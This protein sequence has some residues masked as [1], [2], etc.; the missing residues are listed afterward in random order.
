LLR[1]SITSGLVVGSLLAVASSPAFCVS[2]VTRGG[3]SVRTIDFSVDQ[4]VT[5]RTLGADSGV[6]NG[7]IQQKV[8][9]KSWQPFL[10][11]SFVA[12]FDAFYVGV[13]GETGVTL[14]QADIKAS[15]RRSDEL[16]GIDVTPSYSDEAR[17][18][19]TDLGISLGWRG[20][21]N[22]VLFCGYKAGDT[23]FD[24]GR[25]ARNFS[26]HGPLVGVSYTFASDQGAL[27]VGSAYARLGGKYDEGKSKGVLARDIDGDAGGFS[28]FADW[29]APITQ[30]W[31][32][33][34]DLR[35]QKY[36]FDGDQ[37]SL[38]DNCGNGIVA[39]Q[40]VLLA[41]EFSVKETIYGVSVSIAY[42]FD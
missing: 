9:F 19:R 40:P 42:A 7:E 26:E 33:L 31:R 4:V 12:N 3:V 16:T 39:P 21:E 11:G 22:L 27:T 28:V 32:Y 5:T 36:D 18:E 10:Q 37:A 8:Q 6:L 34:I 29:N 2:Y 24:D 13:N 17:V 1:T 41:R 35:W 30:R 14:D 20:I 25:A 23:D 38:C 15:Q